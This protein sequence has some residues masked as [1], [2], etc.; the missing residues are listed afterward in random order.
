MKHWMV[1]SKDIGIVSPYIKAREASLPL[2]FMT[3]VTI[4]MSLMNEK[5]PGSMDK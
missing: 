2:P 1:I 4:T 3:I 5:A